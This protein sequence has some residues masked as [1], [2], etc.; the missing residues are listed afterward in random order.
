MLRPP[1]VPRMS[2]PVQRRPRPAKHMTLAIG[3]MARHGLVIAAD[4][5]LTI[6]DSKVHHG[7]IQAETRY[8]DENSGAGGCVV[9]GAGQPDTY[10]FECIRKVRAGFFQEPDL[11][12]QD[13][14]D[15]LS[16]VLVNFFATHVAPFATYP[17]EDRPN[18]LILVGY[19]RGTETDLLRSDGTVFTTARP[20]GAVGIGNSH[21]YASLGRMY[22]LP[23][24]D[25]WQ[26]VLLGAYVMHA[27]REAN[28]FV[29]YADICVQTN[30]RHHLLSPDE[31]KRLDRLME[32][33]GKSIEASTFRA[34]LGAANE[35]EIDLAGMHER[36]TEALSD[37]SERCP[38]ALRFGG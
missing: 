6:G 12:G 7:K 23:A 18:L 2:R 33:Y 24:L 29:G 5:Q 38:I 21:A 19:Q 28:I 26:T 9:T 16:N 22:R 17:V 10:L 25:L 20:Y 14:R 31:T 37:L 4:R 11:K 13:L 15:H 32:S 27:A 8:G 34:T 35:S 36:F 3:L 1:P 30:Y